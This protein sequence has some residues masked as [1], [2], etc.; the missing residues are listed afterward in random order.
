[1]RKR[2]QPKPRRCER[3]PGR[4]RGRAGSRAIGRA[5]SSAST[6]R[7]TRSRSIS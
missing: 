2:R 6:P 1:L 7:M 3:E 4:S 5:A